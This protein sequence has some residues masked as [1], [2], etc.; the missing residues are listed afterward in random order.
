MSNILSANNTEY[1][2]SLAKMGLEKKKAFIYASSAAT[3][4]M[5]E[6]GIPPTKPSRK[7]L[8]PLNPYGIQAAV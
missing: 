4:G 2:K 5:A 7:K 3:Y 1:T 6:L 8:K